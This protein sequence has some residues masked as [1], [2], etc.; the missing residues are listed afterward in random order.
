MPTWMPCTVERLPS[1]AEPLVVLPV[2]TAPTSM[3]VEGGVKVRVSLPLVA[4]AEAL[5]VA[6]PAA[7]RPATI[8]PAGMPPPETPMPMVRPAMVESAPSAVEPL[9]VLAVAVTGCAIAFET[10]P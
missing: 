9:V 3:R 1:E 8:V 6:V 5:K 10:C 7:L 2:A 4:V